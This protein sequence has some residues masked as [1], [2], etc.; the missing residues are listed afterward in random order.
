MKSRMS[1]EDIPDKCGF[2]TTE[3]PPSVD[4][5]DSLDLRE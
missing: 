4:R 1:G 2:D 3:L 5:R